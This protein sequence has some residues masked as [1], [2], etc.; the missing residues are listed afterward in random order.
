MFFGCR[1]KAW[2]LARAWLKP[3]SRQLM[4]SEQQRQL[5]Q[6]LQT[7]ALSYKF[8]LL[9]DGVD[10]AELF[11]AGADLVLEPFQDAA[12][13]AVDLLCGAPQAERT[14]IPEIQTE[15]RLAL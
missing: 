12:D 15:G 10:S 7:L 4:R 3:S 5:L 2:Y 9:A 1:A 14:E 13:R 11:A 6:M 8:R